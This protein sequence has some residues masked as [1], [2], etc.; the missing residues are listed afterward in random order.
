[1]ADFSSLA[2]MKVMNWIITILLIMGY[3]VNK[4]ELRAGVTSADDSNFLCHDLRAAVG[5]CTSIQP[6]GDLK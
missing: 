3:H 5:Y 2:V 1:M 4:A 6:N